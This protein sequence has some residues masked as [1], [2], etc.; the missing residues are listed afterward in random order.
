M[1]SATIK[2]VD[3]GFVVQIESVSFLEKKQDVKVYIC[4]DLEEAFDF[5]KANH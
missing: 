5:I 1:F 2:E 4:K 3:N